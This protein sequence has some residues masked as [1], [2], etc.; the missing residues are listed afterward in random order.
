MSKIICD[1][2]SS[3]LEWRNATTVT[4]QRAIGEDDCEFRVTRR[5]VIELCDSC[6]SRLHDFVDEQ[7]DPSFQ[8]LD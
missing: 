4:Y 7:E 2:C 3:P 6:R 5:E 8:R 1:R